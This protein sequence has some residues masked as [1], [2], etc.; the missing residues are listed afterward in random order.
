MPRPAAVLEDDFVAAYRAAPTLTQLADELGQA[1]STVSARAA[2]LRARGIDLPPFPPGRPRV[3]PEVLQVPRWE[4]VAD[5]SL[6]AVHRRRPRAGATLCGQELLQPRAVH[7]DNPRHRCA[8]CWPVQVFPPTKGA[9]PAPRGGAPG[10]VVA[11]VAAGVVRFLRLDLAGRQWVD[12]ET[13]E[14]DPGRVRAVRWWAIHPRRTL[15]VR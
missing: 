10:E 11:E 6:R 5:P 1:K 3:L 13:D 9:I 15:P 2:R 8:S 7:E 12:V 14:V 4:W